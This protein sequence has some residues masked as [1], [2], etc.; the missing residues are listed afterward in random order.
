MCVQLSSG[1][2]SQYLASSRCLQCE[3]QETLTRLH[4]CAGLCLPLL[5]VNAYV[6]PNSYEL[7]QIASFA[8]LRQDTLI[9]A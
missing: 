9:L 2:K 8:S 5:L 1:A 4:G 6:I 3:C 7:V